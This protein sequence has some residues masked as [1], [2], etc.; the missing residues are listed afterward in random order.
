MSDLILGIDPGTVVTGYGVVKSLGG[1]LELIDCG[2]ISSPRSQALPYKYK[3]LFEGMMQLI[4]TY[5]PDVVAVENQFMDKNFQSAAKVAM[6]KG[7]I[8]LAAELKG[9]PIFEYPAVTAK[10]VVT[11]HGRANKT[12]VQRMLRLLFC[13]E[14]E[15]QPADAADALALA[16]C[17]ALKTRGVHVL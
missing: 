15:P 3:V 9:I 11:G 16:I 1:K 13:L 5:Q 6:S 8:F 10:K 4:E 12:D 7:I 2:I 17:H 14:Q